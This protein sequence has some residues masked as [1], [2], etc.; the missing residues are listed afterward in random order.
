MSTFEMEGVVH[1]Y[2]NS[3]IPKVNILHW[4]SLPE[5]P[6]MG[7]SAECIHAHLFFRERDMLT[8]FKLEKEQFHFNPLSYTMLHFGIYK[9]YIGETHYKPWL[10]FS[11]H[12]SIPRHHPLCAMSPS[13]IRHV[14]THQITY[15]C[16]Q[17]IFCGL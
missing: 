17:S 11:Q 1:K 3:N 4:I 16:L 12:A 5:H 9:T 7:R 8:F 15:L 10:Y 2:Y 14:I 6:L 13:T